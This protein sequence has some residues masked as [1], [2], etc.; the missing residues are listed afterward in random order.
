M[1]LVDPPPGVQL[2]Q[3][4]LADE[5]EEIG[6]RMQGAQVQHGIDGIGRASA[7]ETSTSSRTKP[8]SPSMAAPTMAL[9]NSAGAAEAASL[10]GER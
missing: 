4:I 6:F 8:G 3:V 10:W 9:R 1:Q 5:I 7:A 2:R